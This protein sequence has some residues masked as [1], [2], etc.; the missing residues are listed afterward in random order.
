MVYYTAIGNLKIQDKHM[1][2]NEYVGTELACTVY[3][4]LS[5]LRME[6]RISVSIN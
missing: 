2:P 3:P 1:S 6:F 5:G 4:K